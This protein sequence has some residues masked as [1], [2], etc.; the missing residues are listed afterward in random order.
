MHPALSASREGA[1][2]EVASRAVAEA[3][4]LDDAGGATDNVS[5]VAAADAVPIAVAMLSD[6]DEWVVITGL[7]DTVSCLL[8]LDTSVSAITAGATT[9]TDPSTKE[10]MQCSLSDEEQIID[11]HAS[12]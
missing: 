8:S 1:G 7:V 2:V 9:V 5:I 3:A 11:V 4:L 6:S 10:M 12:E